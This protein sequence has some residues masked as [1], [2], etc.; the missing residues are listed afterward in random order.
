[1]KKVFI[2]AVLLTLGFI[3]AGCPARKV[4]QPES[5]KPVITPEE[6]KEK[7]VEVKPEEKITEKITEPELAKIETKEEKP[8]YIE[9]RSPFEDIHFDFDKYDIRPDAK[10]VLQAIASWLLK[11]TSVNILI[12]GHCDERGTDEYNLALGD[13]RAKATRDYLTALGIP[14]NRVE[15][16]S[17][18]E[19]KPLCTDKTEGCW[20]KNRRAH[21]V[22]L[23]ETGR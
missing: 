19:E 4:V 20:A 11:N 23:K 17:Y 22:I 21:F 16:L 3:L 10:P 15:M 5:P 14:S 13:R 9:E 8:K 6:A 2:L 12:E 7:A 18:G 1:M